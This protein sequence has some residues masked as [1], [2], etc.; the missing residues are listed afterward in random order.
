[1]SRIFIVYRHVDSGFIT[2]QIADRLAQQF[3][4]SNIVT[5]A[6]EVP[7]GVNLRDDVQRLA[8]NCSVLVVV[9]G[10]QWATDMRLQDPYDLVRTAIEVSLNTPTVRVM[11][12]MVNGAMMPTPASLPMPIQPLCYRGMT[13]VRDLPYFEQDIQALLANTHRLLQAT[14]PP[15]SSVPTPAPYPPSMPARQSAP[16]PQQPTTVVVKQG[17]NSFGNSLLMLPFTL[18]GKLFGFILSLFGT[19]IRTMLSSVVS[20]IMGI[21]IMLAIGGFTFMFIVAMVNNSGDV[22]A[23]LGSMGQQISQFLGSFLPR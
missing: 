5:V 7:P 11:P 17:G 9:I 4:A 15:M 10:Q 2:R 8:K 20:F 13:G 23:A 6:Q 1:M 19:V 3:G 14:P 12:V 18:V 21:V 16:A 22:S